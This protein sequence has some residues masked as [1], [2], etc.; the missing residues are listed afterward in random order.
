MST[1][2]R[3]KLAL[4][5]CSIVVGVALYAIWDLDGMRKAAIQLNEVCEADCIINGIPLKSKVW[6]HRLD[7]PGCWCH[8]NETTWRRA[9]ALGARHSDTLME[10]P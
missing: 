3:V 8:T 2:N 10:R 6:P 4:G 5:L 9:D 1:K 7:T